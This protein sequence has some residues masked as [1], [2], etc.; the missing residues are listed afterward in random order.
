MDANN[1]SAVGM[2]VERTT[3]LVI[4]VKLAGTTS[5]AAV[6]CF[7]DKLN[8]SSTEPCVCS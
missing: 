7:S 8:E 1:R 2:L 3:H 6:V 5:T 4:L